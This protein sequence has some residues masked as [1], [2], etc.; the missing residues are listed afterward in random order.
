MNVLHIIQRYP[1]SVGGSEA[2]CR[3]LCQALVA[4]GDDVKVLTLDVLEE[5][6][7]WQEP[8]TDRCTLRLG[9]LDRDGQVLVRRY[10]RSLPVYTL[11]HS[12]LKNLFVRRL[13][14][15]LYGPHSIEMYGRLL[16]EV[17]R[18]D[19]VH[20]HT[21]PFPHNLFGFLAARLCRKPV[22]ITPHFHPGHPEYELPS[23]YWL[24]KRCDAVIVISEYEREYLA[25]KGVDPARILTTGIGAKVEDFHPTDVAGFD[26]S[27]RQVHG[28]PPSARPILFLGRKLEYKGVAVLVDAFRR[29]PPRLDAVLLLAG[30]SS[31]WFD[32]F[33]ASLPAADRERIIDLGVVDHADKVHLLHVAEMLALPSQFE[34]YGMVFLEAWACGTPVIA[35]ATGAMP[36]IV[37]DGGLVCEYGNPAD[38]AD[39]MTQLL[40]DP[41]RG[42]AMARGA[43]QRMLDSYSWEKIAAT[44]AKGYLLARRRGRRLRVLICSNLFH[45]HT[46]GGAE[47]VA[48]KEALILRD[49]GVDVEVFC[50]WF[51]PDEGHG[52]RARVEHDDLRKTRVSLSLADISGEWWNFRNATIRQRFAEVLDRFRPDVVHFHNLVGLAVTTVDECAARAIPTV[53][54]LHDYWGICFKNT[55]V[56]NDNALC[57]RGGFDCLECKTT[58]L[59]ESSAPSPVRNSHILLSLAK[60]DRFVSCSRTPARSGSSWPATGRTARPSRRCARSSPSVTS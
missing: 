9:R 5:G 48:H 49:M 36:S 40:E 8:P 32:E 53:M 13:G 18:A 54:T 4:A 25:S 19:V 46:F 30:P 27:L 17:R 47:I 35:A 39:K 41:E 50:G 37:G 1:P 28:L 6:E 51:D 3:E 45:P 22:V 59:G 33:Y 10:K 31:P 38:L 43:R 7:F 26:A 15:Y 57:A 58:L 55:M 60:V 2:W 44:A 29:L 42:R 11:Y 14:I 21:T 52:Y 23:N 24:L 12:V 34:A 20:L 16:S 56:K